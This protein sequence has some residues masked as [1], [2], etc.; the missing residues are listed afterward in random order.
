[1]PTEIE[2]AKALLSEADC[3]LI[4]AGA[5]MG[6]DSGLPDFRGT[7][8]F[9]K[10]YPPY[11]RLGMQFESVAN[12]KNFAEDPAFAWGFYGHRF[13]LY[14]ETKPH[15]GF[16]MLLQY[17]QT[18]AADSFVYTSNVDG[19]F[20]RAGFEAEQVIEC[21]G[22]INHFQCMEACTQAIYPAHDCPEFNIDESDMKAI[23]PL[24]VCPDCQGTARPAILMFGDWGW[25]GGRTNQQQQQ[26]DHWLSQIGDKRVGV[27]EMGAGTAIPTVRLQSEQVAW[28]RDGFLIRINPRECEVPNHIEG[29]SLPMGALE[30][31]E[32]ILV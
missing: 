19:H 17:T 23:E 28:S 11:E 10:A 30:A 8:G 4:T 20:E 13:N 27:I 1:M 12:P 31:L 7:Q 18:L 26:F 25:N 22:S 32:A 15:R 6:V 14:R 29:V 9:W 21:H 24:P 16:E 3:L 5:G 2:A